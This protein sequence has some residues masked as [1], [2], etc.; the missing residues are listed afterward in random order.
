M[1]QFILNAFPLLILIVVSNKPNNWILAA[2]IS[3]FL[4]EEAKI[5]I[6]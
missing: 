4:Q 5:A 6:F 2:H 3:K 1:K